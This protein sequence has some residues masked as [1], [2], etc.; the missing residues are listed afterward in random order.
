MT[1]GVTPETFLIGSE[2]ISKLIAAIGDIY[3]AGQSADSMEK[4]MLASD[5]LALAVHNLVSYVG[6]EATFQ[7]HDSDEIQH[8]EE[9][10][11]EWESSPMGDLVDWLSYRYGVYRLSIPD[12]ESSTDETEE[13]ASNG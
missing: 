5:V 1:E 9:W 7:F 6:A 4:K 11:H 10:V 2:A 8:V 13:D 3:F 12:S